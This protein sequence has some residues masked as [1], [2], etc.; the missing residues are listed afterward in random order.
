M[1]NRK[2]TMLMLFVDYLLCLLLELFGLI[3]FSW[4][5]KFPW[6]YPAYSTLFTLVLFGLLYSRIHSAADRD[7]KHKELKKPTEGLVMAAPLVCFNLLIILIYA[8]MQYNVIPVRDVLMNTLYS[9]PDDAPRVVT[10]LY[11][12]DY[13]TPVVRIWFGHLVG[14]MTETTTPLLLLISPLVALAAV[15]LGY[16]AGGK[17]FYIADVIFKAKEKVKEKFNE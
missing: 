4:M 2:K 12:I 9:F 17:R 5:L 11:L 13:I 1:S 16:F 8:L 15:F 6:G 7:R 14:F 10:K 3:L